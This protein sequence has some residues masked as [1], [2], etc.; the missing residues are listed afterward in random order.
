VKCFV[1]LKD[2]EEDGGPLGLVP[3]SERATLN[4]CLLSPYKCIPAT[5][6]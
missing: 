4:C 6:A 5:H 1:M 2:V 3:G